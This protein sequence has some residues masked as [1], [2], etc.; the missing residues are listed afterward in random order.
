MKITI[1]S[2]YS[3]QVNRG[4]ETWAQNL[5]EKLPEKFDVQ[6]ISGEKSAINV[7][8]KLLYFSQNFLNH[9]LQIIASDIVIPANGSI[10]T[11]LCRIA[12]WTTGRP[13]IVFGHSGPGADDKWNLLCSP[14]IFVVFSEAQKKWAE[15]HKFF[16]T[17]IVIIPHAV[18]TK[19][20]IPAQKKHKAKVVLCVAANLPQKRIGLVKKAVAMLK[21]YKFIAVGKGNPGEVPFSDMPKIYQAADVF[22][23]VPWERE[24]FGLVFLE[25]MAGNLPVVTID[26]VIR[27]EIIGTAGIFVKDPYD[28]KS[29]A[30]AIVRAY[31]KN[32]G[33]IPRRQAEKFAWSKIITKYEKLFVGYSHH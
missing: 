4:V 25:A 15:K 16:W 20:F 21:G 5:K 1:L 18:D 31:K 29:L 9:L 23:F 8:N 10:Q 14:D 17:K 19:R 27:R 28:A 3:G 11:L 6:I 22:C 7:W 2:Y 33:N 13:M 12:T 32:W 26:D 30:S 24:A